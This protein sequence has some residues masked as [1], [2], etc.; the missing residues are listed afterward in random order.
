MMHYCRYSDNECDVLV[1]AVLPLVSSKNNGCQHDDWVVRKYA[2]CTCLRVSHL[3]VPYPLI[4]SNP[5]IIVW[6]IA[7][8]CMAQGAFAAMDHH[9][10]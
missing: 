9:G 2:F 5:I 4:E 1:D 7:H 10:L 6:W 8:N 3:K